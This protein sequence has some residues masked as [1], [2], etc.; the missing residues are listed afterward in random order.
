[1]VESANSSHA[2]QAAISEK[3]AALEVLRNDLENRQPLMFLSDLD[4][5]TAKI[6]KRFS[7]LSSLLTKDVTSARKELSKLLGELEYS[8]IADEGCKGARLS[9]VTNVL[10]LLG[11][12][13]GFPKKNN[14]GGPLS[15]KVSDI[16][17][18]LRIKIP[19]MSKRVAC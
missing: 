10:A 11:V 8:P 1:M 18:V 19:A 15:S 3:E 2:I 17:P 14:S 6:A 16:W 4:Y 12:N 13:G 9:G 5:D 7:A